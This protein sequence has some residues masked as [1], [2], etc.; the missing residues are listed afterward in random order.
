[1]IETFAEYGTAAAKT[2]KVLPEGLTGLSYGS[3]GLSEEQG[4]VAGKIKRLIRDGDGTFDS[5]RDGEIIAAEI[6][7]CLWYLWFLSTVIGIPLEQI[8]T[9]NISKLAD[10]L[11]RGVISGE[12][13]N[14]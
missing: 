5:R 13:D 2:A 14:R 4:E 11:E 8:A 6:G 3:L 9:D 7:D 10:R 1:M 12:G